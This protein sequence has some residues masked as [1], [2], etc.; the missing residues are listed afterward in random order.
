MWSHRNNI[1]KST[2]YCARQ[3]RT[4]EHNHHHHEEHDHV[5]AQCSRPWSRVASKLLS[6]PG[7]W[8]YYTKIKVIFLATTAQAEEDDSHGPLQL[9]PAPSQQ[10]LQ[11]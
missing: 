5:C 6:T 9:S 2:F 10:A 1:A 7:D 4:V 11:Q 8:P 3:G